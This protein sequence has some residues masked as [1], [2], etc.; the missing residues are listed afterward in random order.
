MLSRKQIWRKIKSKSNNIGFCS[1]RFSNT[2]FFGDDIFLESSASIE[3]ND[4]PRSLPNS[5]PAKLKSAL[6]LGDFSK[7]LR[8]TDDRILRFSSKV[9][10]CLIPTR[11]D[12][13]ELGIDH[14]FW[15]S[16]DYG[17]F[18]KEAVDELRAFLTKR[19][20]TAKEAIKQLYQ[21][22]AQDIEEYMTWDKSSKKN[23]SNQLD[24]FEDTSQELLSPE[25]DMVCS[26]PQLGYK[27]DVELNKQR[28][29]GSNSCNLRTPSG[30]PKNAQQVWAV[31][32]QKGS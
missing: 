12:L 9:Q 8:A 3:I 23:S 28:V 14:I 5:S 16:D 30:G 20:I 1:E 26:E 7:A 27:T 19:G 17:V 2:L 29:E 25:N 13:M 24:A 4:N 18:K 6:S 10:V 32:W 11:K 21:P 31:Q 22:S 15:K